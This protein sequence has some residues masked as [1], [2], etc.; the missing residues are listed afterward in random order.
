[1]VTGNTLEAALDYGRERRDAFLEELLAFLRIPSISTDPAHAAQV[2]RAAGWL[3]EALGEAGLDAV[4]VHDTPGHPIVTAEWLGAGADRPTVLVYGHYDV[5]PADPLDEWDSGPFDPVLNDDYL[6]ARGVADDKGQTY[7]HVKAVQSYLRTT[8]RLPVNVKFLIEGEEEMGGPN[9]N[10]FIQAHKEWLSADVA[11][12]SD[13]AMFSRTRPAIIYGLRGMCYVLLDI[14]GPTRDLHSGSYG[15][16]IDNPLNVLGHIV[17]A[18]KDT[19]GHILIPGFYDKVRPLSAAERATLARVQL[20]EAGWLASSGAPRVWGEPEY[21][22]VERIGARPTLDVNGLVGGY[23]G[24]GRKTVLPARAHAKISMRLV[25]DQDPQEIGR[26]FEAYVRQIA[27]PTVKIRMTLSGSPPSIS[28]LDTPAMRAASQA[29]QDVF[30]DETVFM[31]EG[32]SIPVVNSLQRNLGLETVLLGFA[33]P[34][35]RIHSPN[36]RLY[37]PTFY[38]GI[39]TIVRFYALYGEAQ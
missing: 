15:G 22:L 38:R 12:I 1:M 6:V 21:T 35:S 37:L 11:L 19:D 32:G 14:E 39:E 18:L 30:D 28:R 23:T 13:T 5:Q 24:P 9:L 33:Q 7:I 34:D 26:L 17:A 27:P 29:C 4:T 20:D 10:P 3:A 31:R 25:P 2:G 36:E 8:G 16:G